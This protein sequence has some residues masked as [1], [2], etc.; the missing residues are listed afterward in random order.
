MYLYDANGNMTSDGQNCYTYNEDNNV[1]QVRNCTSGQLVT[2]Y[3]YDDQGNRVIQKIYSNGV[4]SKTIYTPT[5]SYETTKLASGTVQNTTYYLVNDQV[6]A[7]KNPDGTK[8][9]YHNDNLNSANVLTDQNGNLV[10]KTTYY[11]FG[12]IQSGGTKSEILYTGQ[13]NDA[14]TGLD[15]YNARYYNPSIMHF[16]QADTVI[17]DVYNPQTLNRYSYVMNN[18]LRYTDSTGHCLEDF[19]IGELTLAA[20]F[21]YINLPEINNAI[22]SLQD[23]P[24][25]QQNGADFL[26]NSN[27]KN[28]INLVNNL[29]PNSQEYKAKKGI[30]YLDDTYNTAQLIQ[31][32]NTVNNE[33]LSTSGRSQTKF[34]QIPT[35]NTSYINT[36]GSLKQGTT[37]NPSTNVLNHTQNS[38]NQSVIKSNIAAVATNTSS[39]PV[40][41]IFTQTQ[42]NNISGKSSS[43][44]FNNVIN[45]WNTIMKL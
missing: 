11:P 27:G 39:N 19:C 34:M 17:P 29:L 8:T 35:V 45:F 32:A 15:Y 10:E 24:W 25:A 22:S 16:T 30:T 6:A 5:K 23:T 18:P 14:T 26:L 1:T 2:E 37:S 7:R 9:Y 36:R 13:R 40:N 21:I 3:V 41:T 44:S 12:G 33:T 31:D 38:N 20:T 28:F 42:K 4:L 43:S